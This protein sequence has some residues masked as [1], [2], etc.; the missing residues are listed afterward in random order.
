M[1]ISSTPA[2]PSTSIKDGITLLDCISSMKLSYVKSTSYS[3]SAYTPENVLSIVN[4]FE[5]HLMNLTFTNI[6]G[7]FSGERK[8]LETLFRMILREEVLLKMMNSY[9]GLKIV[10]FIKLP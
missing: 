7:M 10:K 8:G 5:C 2:S 1:S 3:T 6:K 9:F 4:S